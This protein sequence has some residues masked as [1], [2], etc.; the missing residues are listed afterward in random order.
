M[1]KRQLLVLSAVLLRRFCVAETVQFSNNRMLNGYKLRRRSIPPQPRSKP[2]VVFPTSLM[3][4]NEPMKS[5]SLIE[6]FKARMETRAKKVSIHL[7][8]VNIRS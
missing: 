6:H 4:I 8:V 2:R 1:Y 5:K 3:N 7:Y